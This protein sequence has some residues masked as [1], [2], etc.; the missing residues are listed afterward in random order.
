MATAGQPASAHLRVN[1]ECHLWLFR[2]DDDAMWVRF[3]SLTDTK[4]ARIAQ[5]A[6]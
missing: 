2:C 1:P 6:Y 5:K 4:R 3:V